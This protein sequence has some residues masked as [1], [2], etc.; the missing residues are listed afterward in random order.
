MARVKP[1][2]ST[3]SGTYSI[4]TRV[5][6]GFTLAASTPRVRRSSF[7]IAATHDSQC[8]SLMVSS[9]VALPTL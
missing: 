7:S 6:A 8:K 3:S 9:V 2:S 1:A 4:R 5:V